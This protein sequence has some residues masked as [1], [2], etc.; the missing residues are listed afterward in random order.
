MTCLTQTPLESWMAMDLHKRLRSED[1]REVWI[2]TGEGPLANLVGAPDY[3]PS[4]AV[5][6]LGEPNE[7]VR[8]VG[9]YGVN[10]KDGH[11]WS[12]WTDDL[13]RSEMKCIMD[14]TPSIVKSM[15]ALA[16]EHGHTV[17][18]N[19]VMASNKV[20]QR[21]LRLSGCFNQA[22]KTRYIGASRTPMR[23]FQTK[24][25]AELT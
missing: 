23:Y 24:P 2:M 21:W 13:K 18:D 4:F 14:H 1:V 22:E 12:L 17:L 19:H 15:V 7:K 11:I 25:L 5:W 20:A 8:L 9:A 16:E 6:G 3:G 10:L